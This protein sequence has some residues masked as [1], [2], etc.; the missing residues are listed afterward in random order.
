MHTHHLAACEDLNDV[1]G[2]GRPDGSRQARHGT[3]RV[4][5]HGVERLAWCIT[6]SGSRR[7]WR[8][9]AAP[10]YQTFDVKL[11]IGRGDWQVGAYIRN[12]TNEAVVYE[13]NQVGYRFG[14]LRT[15]GVQFNYRL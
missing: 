15:F 11:L 5:V 3:R 6:N 10:A 8:T 4:L 1:D 2:R 9:D 7:P 14:R 12:L 13:L